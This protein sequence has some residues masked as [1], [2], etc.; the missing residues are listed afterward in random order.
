MTKDRFDD[1]RGRQPASTDG[2]LGGFMF[3]VLEYPR[4]KQKAG[5]GL[6]LEKAGSWRKRGQVYPCSPLSDRL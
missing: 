5:S 2:E 6:S 3:D 4:L 1:I